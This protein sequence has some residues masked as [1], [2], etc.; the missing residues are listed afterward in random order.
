MALRLNVGCLVCILI[1]AA[2]D[3]APRAHPRTSDANEVPTTWQLEGPILAIG[4][5]G[6]P[7]YEFNSVIAGHVLDDGELIIVDGGSKQVRRYNAQ[8]KFINS[9]GKMGEGPGEFRYLVDAYIADDGTTYVPDY[10][11]RR[12][13]K[14]SRAGKVAGTWPW[15]SGSRIWSVEGKLAGDTLLLGEWRMRSAAEQHAGDRIRDTLTLYAMPLRKSRFGRI[16]PVDTTSVRPLL[17]VPSTWRYTRLITARNGSQG[18]IDG[19][20]FFTPFATVAS[21]ERAI[22]VSNSEELRVDV[23]AHLGT[24]VR[25][26]HAPIARTP[27][28]QADLDALRDHE[29]VNAR[30]EHGR[31]FPKD[32]F[33]RKSFE[34]YFRD[35]PHAQYKPV[36]ERII[37]DSLGNVWVQAYH[38]D[39]ARAA[40]KRLWVFSPGG[41]L[42]TE[43]TFPERFRALE[44]RPSLILGVRWDELGVE[45][46]EL[47]R[48][49]RRTHARESD[50]SSPAPCQGF[51][52]KH[53]GSVTTAI[54]LEVTANC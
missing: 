40:P 7:H 46:I 50:A 38:T 28:T 53:H 14:I 48:L 15:F 26:L 23:H 37:P 31:P 43:V 17:R 49:A 39:P 9:I 25:E 16:V 27:V 29:A 6:D 18:L 19:G 8:G 52:D 33:M 51:P 35:T 21:N 12:V 2:C 32:D 30:D 36:L 24:R 20:E 41:A 22:Y 11:L 34:S 5:E 54:W 44:I 3:D 47:Y 13:T 1:C 4:A 45:R 10:M 42:V